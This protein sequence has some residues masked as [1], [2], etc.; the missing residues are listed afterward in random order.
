MPPVR[1]RRHETVLEAFLNKR[2]LVKWL[3]WLAFALMLYFFFVEPEVERGTAAAKSAM[4]STHAG[5]GMLLGIV[6]LLWTVIYWRHGALGRPGPKLPGWGKRMH[7]VVNI[8]LYWMLP[9]TVL[10]GGIAGLASDYPVLGFGVIP[11]NPAGWGTASLHGIAEEIHEIVFDATLILI[12][13]HLGFHVWRH[14]RL[15]D[16]ALRIMFPKAL[17]KW[18]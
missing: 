10:S 12:L 6:A 13:A 18:L 17:H 15:R 9:L 7:R 16:N 5:M 8:G 11:L 3:H 1:S 4:L 14:Y 2:T